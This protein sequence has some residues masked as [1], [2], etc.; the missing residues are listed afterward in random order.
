MFHLESLRIRSL[1]IC[2]VFLQPLKPYRGKIWGGFLPV[3]FDWFLNQTRD[4]GRCDGHQAIGWSERWSQG[5]RKVPTPAFRALERCRLR[6]FCLLKVIFYRF[7]HGKSPLEEHVLL[8]RTT[9]S[10][11]HQKNRW[12]NPSCSAKHVLG[13]LSAQIRNFGAVRF[14]DVGG[15]I[16]YG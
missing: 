9:F 1:F 12:M 16:D 13:N 15:I 5:H 14:F 10:K 7:Y 2:A 6:Y 8:V 3:G 11:Q 4:D